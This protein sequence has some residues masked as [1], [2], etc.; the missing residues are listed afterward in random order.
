MPL[1]IW[2]VPGKEILELRNQRGF[3]ALSWKGLIG[4]APLTGS[5]C[6]AFLSHVS[7]KFALSAKF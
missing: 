4:R 3:L 7:S 6:Q 2:Q 5:A 1:G